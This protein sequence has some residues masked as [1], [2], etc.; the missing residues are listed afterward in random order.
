MPKPIANYESYITAS[1]SPTDTTFNV[2]SDLDD[3]GNTIGNKTLWMLLGPERVLATINPATKVGTFIRRGVDPADST[4]ERTSLKGEH[5]KGTTIKITDAHYLL[6]LSETLLGELPLEGVPK[7]PV[8]RTISNARDVVDKEYA[9][10]LGISAFPDFVVTGDTGLDI[11]INAGTL[12]TADGVVEFA[13]T[14]GYTLDDDATNYVELTGDGTVV[15]NTNSFNIKRLPLAEVVTA[16][17][18]VISVSIKRG[19]ATLPAGDRSITTDY[20]YG[21]TISELDVVYLDT[22][23]GKW[24]P[25]SGAGSA[26]VAGTLG[27]A[28]DAGVDTDTGKRVQIG[29]FVSGLSGLTPGWQYASDTP[30]ELSNTP[31]TY[32]KTVGYAPDTTSLVLVKSVQIEGLE[33]GNANVTTAN[34]NKLMNFFDQE[35]SLKNSFAGDGSDGVLD[36]DSGTE[37]IDLGGASFFQLSYSSISITGTGQLN[38]TNPHPNGTLVQ[39]KSQGDV[40]ITSSAPAI[41]LVGMGAKGGEGKAG[42]IQQG[43]VGLPAGGTG[44]LVTRFLLQEDTTSIPG[45]APPFNNRSGANGGSLP[46]NRFLYTIFPERISTQ[47]RLLISPGSGG[48]SGNSGNAEDGTRTP[49]GDSGRGGNGGGAL[50]LHCG[51]SFN[52]TGIIDISGEDGEDGTSVTGTGGGINARGRA[53]AAGGGGSAGMAI[54]LYNSLTTNTGSVRCKGG[55]GGQGGSYTIIGSSNTTDNYTVVAGAGAASMI[56]TGAATTAD[57]TTWNNRSGRDGLSASNG[58]GASGG[59]G[60]WRSSGNGTTPGG[61][62]GISADVSN[63]AGLV[64]ITENK[65]FN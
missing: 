8:D 62:G 47:N 59:G 63:L 29:G 3:A 30:G 24:K 44:D 4:V 17:G 20:E 27:I 39:I 12:V 38:F 7:L 10:S 18:S 14:T 51:G 60:A 58:A 48:S 41:D 50:T 54:I 33:G 25:A 64:L 52:F 31:G 15:H 34:F 28:L 57:V 42:G 49:G 9:D 21:D 65:Y 36:I 6:E 61:N 56:A 46:I 37:T 45:Q 53:G 2:F 5:E 19:L 35:S 32:K 16:S 55:N 1:V 11:N 43:E 23:D 13:G 22:A 26:T 40:T